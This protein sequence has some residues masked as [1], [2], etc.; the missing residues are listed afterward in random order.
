MT[1][2]APLRSASLVDK[3]V[4]VNAKARR[5]A[6]RVGERVRSAARSAE[7]VETSTLAE[8]DDAVARLSSRETPPSVAILVGGDG[9]HMAGVSAIAR[10]F[11][12]RPM[13]RVALASG[14]TVCT[15]ARAW[16][17]RGDP[18]DDVARA[19]AS[20]T[21]ETR[22][23]LAI[24]SP[25]APR[26]V[27]FIWGTGLV[28]RF[29]EPYDAQGGGVAAAAGIAAR[30]FG[31]ALAGTELARK[32]LS[33]ISAELWIDG[34]RAP[35]TGWSLAVSSVLRDVGLGIRV[36]YRAGEDPER[37]HFVASSASPRGLAAAFPS[38][39][40]GRSM[41]DAATVD[42]LAREVRVRFGD[43]DGGPW[44]LDGDTF[45]TTELTLSAGPR[46][47]VVTLR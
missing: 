26:R 16:G 18:A 12:D 15:T 29:F 38:T 4:I 23:T 3:V 41:G 5:L 31:S 43:P 46:L 14:G 45:R 17:S 19:L 36:T 7:L 44:V 20:E 9:T 40:L 37:I 30:V 28:A 21:F 24:E 47:D 13:P 35:G 39:F 10:A 34:A 33:P 27:G 32:V 6:G 8:L 1:R 25:R 42:A 2:Q 11:G 22:G